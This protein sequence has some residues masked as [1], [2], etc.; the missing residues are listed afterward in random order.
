MT[1]RGEGLARWLEFGKKTWLNEVENA[2]KI[3]GSMMVA[4]SD[5]K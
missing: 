1:F 2:V 5:V 3:I 4:E